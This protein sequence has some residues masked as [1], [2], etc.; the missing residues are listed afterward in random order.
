MTQEALRAPG[1]TGFSTGTICTDSNLYRCSDDAFEII[2]Y[3]A[4]GQP[5]PNGPFGNGKGKTTWFKI[6]LATDG[7]RKSFD[8]AK[9]TT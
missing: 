4:A 2:E 7:H 3:V 9:L 6:T 1:A 5:F 8:A